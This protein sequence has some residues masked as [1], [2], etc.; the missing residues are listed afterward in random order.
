MLLCVEG[1][2]RG[3]CVWAGGGGGYMHMSEQIDMSPVRHLRPMPI[4]V[5]RGARQP[6]HVRD[7]RSLA[8]HGTAGSKLL[9]NTCARA[10]STQQSRRVGTEGLPGVADSYITPIRA[11]TSGAGCLLHAIMGAP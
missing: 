9:A 6:V 8:V 1:T 3:V 11:D 5:A 4:V 10:L 7:E 2:A